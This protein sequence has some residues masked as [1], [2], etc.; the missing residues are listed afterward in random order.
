M[1][2]IQLSGVIFGQTLSLCIYDLI[3]FSSVILVAKIVVIF[4]V[5]S[6]SPVF[7]HLIGCFTT[8]CPGKKEA[9]S[10]STISLVFLD[11]FS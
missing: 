8:P 6:R 11:R 7:D 5:I 10:F 1:R 2:T 9:I 4:S 3:D